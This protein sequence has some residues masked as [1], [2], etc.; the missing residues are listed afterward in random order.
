MRF[1]INAYLSFAVFFL[2]PVCMSQNLYEKV[3]YVAPNEE[4][5][6]NDDDNNLFIDT[7]GKF[8]LEIRIGKQ[9]YFFDGENQIG[10]FKFIGSTNDISYTCDI[11]SNKEETFWYRCKLSTKVYGPVRGILRACLNSTN[12]RGIALQIE[13]NDSLFYY[14]NGKLVIGFDKEIAREPFGNDWC[15][16]NSRGEFLLNVKLNNLDLLYLNGEL[17]DSAY[18]ISYTGF[19]DNGNYIYARTSTKYTNDSPF[20]IYYNKGVIFVG[21]GF[22]YGKMDASGSFYFVVNDEDGQKLLFKEN[23]FQYPQCI[24]ENGRID[25]RSIIYPSFESYIK[26]CNVDLKGFKVNYNGIESETYDGIFSECADSLGNFVFFGLKDYYIYPVVNGKRGDS[27]SKFGFRAGPVFMTTR[28]NHYEY[29]KTAD[30][31]YLCY[32]NEIIKSESSKRA[33]IIDRLYERL[34]DYDAPE[35][36]KKTAKYMQFGD[37]SYFFIRDSIY[38]SYLPILSIYTDKIGSIIISKLLEGGKF[39]FIQKISEKSF[40]LVLNGI[41]YDPIENIDEIA[42]HNYFIVERGL[43]FFGIKGNSILQY[44]TFER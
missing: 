34:S 9:K 28:G 15:K 6:N 36:L 42:R 32:N 44:S 16:F 31:I 39:F 11:L 8:C 21:K 17:I 23:L 10:P 26:C 18:N 41:K 5:L 29:Y 22:Y 4:M 37:S 35:D 20:S 19:D 40:Q 33:F 27:I 2:I 24:D 30:S 1:S 12:G 14:V 25:D 13:R 38:G 43:I 7:N 3:I